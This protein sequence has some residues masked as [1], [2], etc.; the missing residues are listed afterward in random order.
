MR[1]AKLIK[2]YLWSSAIY[3][4]NMHQ[5][6][7]YDFIRATGNTIIHNNL[8]FRFLFLLLK[9]FPPKRPAMGSGRQHIC[10]I[11]DSRFLHALVDQFGHIA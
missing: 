10:H 3:S 9:I 6:G 2:H 7:K 4:V 8:F 1:L 5:I 11:N